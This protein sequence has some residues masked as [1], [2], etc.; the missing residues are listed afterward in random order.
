MST[1]QKTLPAKS[2]PFFGSM[3]RT[4]NTFSTTSLNLEVRPSDR[5]FQIVLVAQRIDSCGKETTIELPSPYIA[6]TAAEARMI[7]A[8]TLAPFMEQLMV[9]GNARHES[10]H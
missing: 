8:D 3:Q 9:G 6:S 10:V 2:I 5:G 1:T 7:V 4:G